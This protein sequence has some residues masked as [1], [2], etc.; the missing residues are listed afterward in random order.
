MSNFNFI[1]WLSGFI[2]FGMACVAVRSLV[3]NY[4]P[5]VLKDSMNDK[6]HKELKK[7]WPNI[8][9][10][11]F[12]IKDHGGQFFDNILIVE[13]AD[14]YMFSI[15]ISHR[16]SLFG[17]IKITSVNPILDMKNNAEVIVSIK[18]GMKCKHIELIKKLI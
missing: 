8:T 6:M 9:L 7:V 10:E 16:E 5:D 1:N 13:G 15:S 2:I 17:G 11:D 4:M 14:E 18:R 3:S 12:V